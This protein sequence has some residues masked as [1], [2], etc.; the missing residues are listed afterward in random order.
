MV[1]FFGVGGS[2]SEVTMSRYFAFLRAINVGGHTV[3]MEVLRSIFEGLGFTG[4]KTFIAS[5]NVVFETTVR[6]TAVLEAQIEDRL[7]QALGFEVITFLRMPAELIQIAQFQP[8]KPQELA[9]AAA[10]NIAFLKGPLE[11]VAVQKLMVLQTEIDK[12]HVQGREVYWLCRE[13]QSESTFSNAVLEKR[14]GVH[15]TLRGVN[16]IKKMVM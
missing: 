15:S 8:F 12:F 2:Q 9:K 4:V 14:L 6:N 1:D 16:T 11:E 7:R 10:F 3:R 13:K 5:G